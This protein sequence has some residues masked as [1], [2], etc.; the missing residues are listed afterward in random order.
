VSSVRD[1]S[2]PVAI[3]PRKK[4]RG[5]HPGIIGQHLQYM[6]NHYVALDVK[7]DYVL[8]FEDAMKR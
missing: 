2:E 6:P 7:T 1:K 4:L 5:H 8:L 3:S